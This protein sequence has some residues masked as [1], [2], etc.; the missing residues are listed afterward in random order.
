MKKTLTISLVLLAASIIPSS[1]AFDGLIAMDAD[2]RNVELGQIIN[3]KGYIYGGYP[4]ENGIVSITV[5]EQETKKMILK[6]DVIPDSKSVKYFENTAW[7]FTFQVDT[8][9]PIFSSDAKYVVEARYDDKSTKLDFFIQPD[10]GPTCL[11]ILGD[12]PIIVLTDK[13]KYDQGDIIHV[14]GCLSEATSETINIIVYDPD[15]NKIGTST[16]TPNSDRTFAEDFV[17]DKRF[18]LNG[19][20][21][22]EADAGGLFT[23]TKSFVVPE[24]GSFAMMIF[25]IS[26]IFI[27]FN[28][29]AIRKFHNFIH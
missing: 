12:N 6:M 23:S 18:G 25:A 19:T 13:E 21:S 5:S 20:Y 10:S 26:F 8:S 7:P 29:T 15:G 4:I 3:Y 1:F 11:E 9:A 14:S 27:L 28:K 16:L 22:L 2:E 24:F 17:I